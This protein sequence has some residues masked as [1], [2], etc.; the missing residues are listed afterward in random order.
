MHDQN[1]SILLCVSSICNLPLAL[2]MIFLYLY[3]YFVKIFL[4]IIKI[5]S[6]MCLRHLN[7][8]FYFIFSFNSHASVMCQPNSSS[9]FFSY[10]WIS[11]FSLDH[12]I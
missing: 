9:N 5:S 10:R 4:I 3:I 7:L 6:L 2:N 12:W 11:P 1:M 8:L